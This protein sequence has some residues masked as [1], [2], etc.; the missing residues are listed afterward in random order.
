[1][2]PAHLLLVV[3]LSYVYTCQTVL[4]VV[5]FRTEAARHQRLS[6]IPIGIPIGF[7]N[8]SAEKV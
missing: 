2:F 7:L 4:M 5:L 8:I 1:M 3:M 6:E